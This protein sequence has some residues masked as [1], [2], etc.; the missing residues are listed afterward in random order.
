MSGLSGEVASASHRGVALGPMRA[1]LLR[2]V[3]GTQSD[4]SQ[5]NYVPPTALSRLAAVSAPPDPVRYG[6]GARRA[7]R[8]RDRG[9]RRAQ[10]FDSS[11]TAADPSGPQTQQDWLD[12]LNSFSN[13]I[14]ALENYQ[15]TRA[16]YISKT[17]QRLVENN[18]RINELTARLE[19]N[20]T[21]R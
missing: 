15:R 16:H 1:P 4:P 3:Q 11:N 21:G 19:K 5:F 2:R 17:D 8:E 14:E 7:S 10:Q 9:Y 20:P 6:S 18:S 12:A 13:R